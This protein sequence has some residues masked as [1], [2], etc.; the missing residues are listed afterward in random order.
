[1]A[2]ASTTPV[3]PARNHD[4]DLASRTLAAQLEL[5]QR[6]QLARFA[7]IFLIVLVWLIQTGAVTY[8]SITDT[9]ILNDV[10]KFIGLLAVTGGL[11]GLLVLKLWP[12]NEKTNGG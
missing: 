9:A 2:S 7:V 1:M 8:A 3:T 6:Q 10:E 4:Q 11:S 5:Q 12:E